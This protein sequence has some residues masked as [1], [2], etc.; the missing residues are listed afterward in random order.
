MLKCCPACR[1]SGTVG[2][3]LLAVI[4]SRIF[5]SVL[6]TFIR[7]F[8]VQFY[9]DVFFWNTLNGSHCLGCGKLSFNKCC[10]MHGGQIVFG[11]SVKIKMQ[12]YMCNLLHLGFF[13]H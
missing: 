2:L 10:V 12:L 6:S 7:L 1:S 5:L 8:D 13:Y 4:H 3:S 9:W 11:D